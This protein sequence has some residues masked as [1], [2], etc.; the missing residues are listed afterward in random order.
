MPTPFIPAPTACRVLM[1]HQQE[2]QR[3]ENVYH[4][5]KDDGFTTADLVTCASVFKSWEDST[6]Q[7]LRA[8]NSYLDTIVATALDAETSPAI[9]YTTGLPIVGEAGTD[10]SP[11]NVTVAV[12]WNTALRG[13]S[14]RGRTYHIGL[15][16]SQYQ[17]S[18]LTT[19]MQSGLV[20][21]YDQ[22]LADLIAEGMVLVVASYRHAKAWRTEALLT[23][24]LNCSVEITLDSQR[25]RL[26]GRGN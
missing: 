22:L 16:R 12:R 25:R 4:C 1:Q 14:F 9:V 18:K 13:R 24:I 10:Y 3:V 23:T 7:V 19:G 21:A 17:Q 26:P 2:G 8:N 11:M 6:M 20:A 5:V 15:C